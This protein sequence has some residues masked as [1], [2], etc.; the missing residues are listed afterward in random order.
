MPNPDYATAIR[1]QQVVRHVQP[2]QSLDNRLPHFPECR[3]G[4]PFGHQTYRCPCRTHSSQPEASYSPDENRHAQLA[5][6]HPRDRHDSNR[7]TGKIVPA[8][9]QP[10]PP[11]DVWRNR[12]GP[13]LP[14]YHEPDVPTWQVF[15]GGTDRSELTKRDCP[16]GNL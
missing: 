1:R 16:G 14:P 15:P 2:A 6:P 5:V 12:S 8:I 7:P 4:S 9:P 10:L 3:N 11:L 13:C